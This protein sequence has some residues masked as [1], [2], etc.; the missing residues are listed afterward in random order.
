M[1]FIYNIYFHPLRNYPGP[2]LYRVSKLPRT[3][4]I[5]RGEW[6]RELLG[7]AEKY[8]PVVR[9]APNVLVYTTSD[10]WKDVYGHHNGADVKGEEFGK[11][12]HFYRTKGVEPNILAESRDN[13]ALIR[14]Q[15]SHGFS[16]K[17]LRAQEPIIK[18]YVD[19]FINGLRDRCVADESSEKSVAPTKKTAFDMRHWFNFVTFDVIGDLAVGE[20]FGCLEQG[21]LDERVA[22]IEKGIQTGSIAFVLKDIGLERCTQWLA[23]RLV[24]FRRTVKDKMSAVLRRRMS[25]TMERPDL[26]EGLLKKQKDWD[27]SFERLRTNTTFL[28]IAGSETTATTLAGCLFLLLKNP[29]AL[30]KLK[31]EIR[32]TFQS[33]D[34]ITFASVERL[35]YMI[36]CFKETFRMYPPVAGEMPRVVPKGGGHVA[37]QFVPEGTTVAAAQYAMYNTSRNFSDPFSFKPERFL[38]P[39]KF[40]NDDR[41]ALQP[42]SS[43]PRNCIGKNL[44]YAELRTM[45]AR[46]IYNFDLELVDPDDDWMNQKVFFI[47]TKPPLNVY[48]TPVER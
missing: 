16:E 46:L 44:A 31:K 26:I 3:Y 22:F 8:G 11:D 17:Y 6:S 28:I 7:L 37:G 47:W 40:P 30:D 9:V 18:G 1:A 13:H 10:V 2:L 20:P 19:M 32:S 33:E 43:G 15:L 48:L 4:S 34:E 36:A 29:S 5:F 14:R 45:M 12:P 38:E 42:F 27:I 39:E 23:R 41:N 24:T 35:D 25:M 21:K